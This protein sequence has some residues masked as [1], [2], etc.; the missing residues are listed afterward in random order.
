MT[1]VISSSSIGQ[2]QPDLTCLARQPRSHEFYLTPFVAS[3]PTMQL[4][5]DYAAPACTD[6]PVTLTHKMVTRPLPSPPRL[7]TKILF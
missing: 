6:H 1:M 4:R 5:S 7:L 2:A 3:P